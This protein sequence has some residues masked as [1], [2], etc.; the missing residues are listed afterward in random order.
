MG[1]K[2]KSD[3]SRFFSRRMAWAFGT[4]PWDWGFFTNWNVWVVSIGKPKYKFHGEDVP[5]WS[6]GISLQFK[7]SQFII[8][9]HRKAVLWLGDREW[10]KQ[11]S[12][13]A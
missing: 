7:P 11:A 2:F 4:W 12:R 13:N 3:R 10:K 5:E 6:F 1:R 9:R 8:L